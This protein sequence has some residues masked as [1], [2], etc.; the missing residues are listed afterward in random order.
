LVF[1]DDDD[2]DDIFLLSQLLN[3]SWVLHACSLNA[4]Q[5]YFHVEALI[6]ASV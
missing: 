2:D 3:V 5:A 4:I 6:S 1:Y